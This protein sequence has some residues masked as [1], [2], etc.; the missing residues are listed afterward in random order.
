MIQ[1]IENFDRCVIIAK[2]E[3]ECKRKSNQPVET[4]ERM[5]I[6]RKYGPI[7]RCGLSV[8]GATCPVSWWGLPEL[9]PFARQ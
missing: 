8:K 5:F 1:T 4:D 6:E 9:Y 7:G 3:K 2:V